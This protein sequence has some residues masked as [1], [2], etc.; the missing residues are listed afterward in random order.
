MC[1]FPT[2]IFSVSHHSSVPLS[3]FVYDTTLVG[4]VSDTDESEYRHEVSS[5]VSWCDTN[6]LQ[7]NASKTREMI[8]DFR[9]RK[10]PLAPIIVNGD[11]I[12]R[13]D[14]LF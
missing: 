11:S 14:G 5:L 10:N 4:L 1:P 9:K 13:V 12:E 8:V 7:L 3:K 6:N 2:A